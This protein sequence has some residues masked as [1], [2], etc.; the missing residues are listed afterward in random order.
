MCPYYGLPTRGSLPKVTNNDVG[1]RGHIRCDPG[2]GE[3]S[4]LP[5]WV[6]EKMEVW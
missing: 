5:E 3:G 4:F 2:K 1:A 6:A